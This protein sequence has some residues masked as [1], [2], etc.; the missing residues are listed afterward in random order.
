MYL[1]DI[2]CIIQFKAVM[3]QNETEKAMRNIL[4]K[5]NVFPDYY[6]RKAVKFL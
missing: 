4:Y 6:N 5:S 2:I 3:K 1:K